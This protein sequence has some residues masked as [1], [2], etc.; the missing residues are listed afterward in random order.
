MLSA[1]INILF[2]FIL[3]VSSPLYT[4]ND[5][6]CNEQEKYS[7]QCGIENDQLF[8][9]KWRITGSLIPI[10]GILPRSYS[11]FD[12]NGAFIGW[13]IDYI[14][15]II[16]EEILFEKDYVFYSGKKHGY[17]HEPEIHTYALQSCEHQIGWYTAKELGLTGDCY[18]IVYFLLPGN[19]QVIGFENYKNVVMIDDLYLLYLK[20]KE[21]MYASNGV[22]MYQLERVE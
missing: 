22:I 17:S 4:K 2:A 5:L 16:G 14:N 18:S 3:V 9:G 1:C 21:T 20:D 15:S 7:L 12:E 19:L 10:S 11:K 13:D 6:Q 8:Y